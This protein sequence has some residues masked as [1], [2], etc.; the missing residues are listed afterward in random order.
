MYLWQT[1]M[2]H[3]KHL[4]NGLLMLFLPIMIILTDEDKKNIANML[5]DANKYCSFPDEIKEEDVEKFMGDKAEKEVEKKADEVKTEVPTQVRDVIPKPSDVEKPD[6]VP[7]APEDVTIAYNEYEQAK[8]SYM[9]LKAQ[10]KDI[11]DKAKL[12]ASKFTEEHNVPGVE[13][14]WHN[15]IDK[16]AHIM[17]QEHMAIASVGDRFVALKDEIKDKPTPTKEEQIKNIQEQIATLNA[18]M[19]K[20]SSM[21]DPIPEKIHERILS[22]FNKTKKEKAASVL[23]LGDIMGDLYESLRNLVMDTKDI[24]ES[25]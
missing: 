1:I 25:I 7:P 13:K 11:S 9:A 20:I 16:L 17:E 12:D 21:A 8:K 23:G 2:L 6:V 24:A 22:I 5:P 4:K 18:D 3:G 10:L 14:E 15:M 19:V